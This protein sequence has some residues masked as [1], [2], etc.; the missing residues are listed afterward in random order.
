MRTTRKAILIA[1]PAALLVAGGAGASFAAAAGGPG[2]HPAVPH[3]AVH[4]TPSAGRGTHPG[5]GNESDQHARPSRH[6]SPTTVATVT[7]N[8]VVTAHHT[9]HHTAGHDAG[10]GGCDD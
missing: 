6:L 4:G 7:R 3:S 1:V 10:G 8:A 2:T 9:A 5:P